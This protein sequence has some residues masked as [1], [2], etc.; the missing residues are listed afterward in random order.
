MSENAP[1]RPP[2]LADHYAHCEAHLRAGDRDGWLAM[3][4]APA[5]KRPHLHALGAFLLEIL[6]VRERVKEPMAGELRLQWWRDAIEGEARGDV[7][8]HPVAAALLDT[9]KACR[10]RRDLL[11]DFIEAHRF[12]LYDD[13]MPT[14]LDWETYCEQTA[15][16]PIRLASVILT[17]KGEPGGIAAASHA[18]VALSVRRQL[19]GLAD[20]TPVFV[21]ADLLKRHGL[22]PADIEAGTMTPLVAAALADLCG[23]ARL[24]LEALRRHLP[25]VEPAAL[26]AYLTTS[27]VEPTLKLAERPGADPF[28][29]P[30]LLPRWKRQWYLWRASR[31]AAG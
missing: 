24:H 29:A 12:D 20:R 2:V 3:L 14:L 5:D 28:H 22:V 1:A 19:I 8:A 9:I 31:R 23:I 13:P 11:T 27:L 16:G 21:P 7:G 18:G 26:P 10:L 25:S 6:N 4:F 15:A 17:G 30:P